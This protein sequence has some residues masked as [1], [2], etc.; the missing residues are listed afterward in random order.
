MTEVVQ[1][2]FR[3]EFLNR[4]DEIALFQRLDADHMAPILDI[5]VSPVAK[6][7]EDRKVSI[8]PSPPAHEWLGRVGNDPVHGARPRKRAVRK[9]LQ[10]PLPDLILRSA[11]KNGAT[12]RVDEGDGAPALSVR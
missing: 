5:Q 9:Y 4:L 8:D 2:H 7:L 12:A 6:L 1:T 11:L 10:D 3:P